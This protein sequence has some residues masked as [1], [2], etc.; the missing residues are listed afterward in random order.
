MKFFNPF[1]GGETFMTRQAFTASTDGRTVTAG[2]GVNNFTVCKTA[3]WALHW[4][5]T[6]LGIIFPEF[7][8]FYPGLLQHITGHG[9]CIAFSVIDGPNAGIYKHLCAYNTGKIGAV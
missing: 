1:I 2:P 4:I 6:G 3:K 8:K 9:I 5:L 7:Y